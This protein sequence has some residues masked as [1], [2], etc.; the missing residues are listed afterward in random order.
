MRRT[1]LLVPLAL[2]ALVPAPADAAA[3]VCASADGTAVCSPGLTCAPLDTIRVTVTGVA[4]G[5]VSCG[6]ATA[7]CIAFRG[8]CTAEATVTAPGTITCEVTHKAVATC[9]TSVTLR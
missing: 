8:F 9:A 4:T 1:A 6:G 3:V 2:L 7:G 5:S